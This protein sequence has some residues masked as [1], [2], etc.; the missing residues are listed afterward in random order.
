VATPYLHS[1]AACAGRMAHHCR[2]PVFQSSAPSSVCPP[3]RCAPTTPAIRVLHRPPPE[4]VC[5]PAVKL[6]HRLASGLLRPCPRLPT[7]LLCR[8]IV[9]V[10]FILNVVICRRGNSPPRWWNAPA[11]N[12]KMR[13]GLSVL[14]ASR[15][16]H[17][18]TQGFRVVQTAR[19]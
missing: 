3:T 10:S 13:R 8:E 1:S 6:P 14:P 11:L 7:T 19:A 18:N 9:L 12:P 15:D 16:E 4:P 5:S 17:K 2:R